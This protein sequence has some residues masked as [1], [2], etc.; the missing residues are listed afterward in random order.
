MKLTLA[1]IILFSTGLTFDGC[2]S[3]D[4]GGPIQK[5]ADQLTAEGWTAYGVKNYQVASSRFTEALQVDGNFADAHNGAGWSNAKL[6]AMTAAV[7]SFTTGLTKDPANLQMKTG[8]AFVYSVQKEYALSL[9]RANEVLAADPA[10]S[11]SRDLSISA[12]DLHL[13]L[14]EDYFAEGDF[15]AS[16]LQVRLL[17]PSFNANVN[18]TAGLAALSAEIERLRVTV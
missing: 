12:S 11:F 9:Q 18:T 1:L 3:N 5:T 8:L 17:N 16:L 2:S 13:L 10:W 4:G 6:N 14:A 7:A 15:S